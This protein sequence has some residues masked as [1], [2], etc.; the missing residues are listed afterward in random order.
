MWIFLESAVILAW[1]G[2]FFK[3]YYNPLS[4]IFITELNTLA[5]ISFSTKPIGNHYKI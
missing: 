2:F 1:I 4:D 5:F 3:R